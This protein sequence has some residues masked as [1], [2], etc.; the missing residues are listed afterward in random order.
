MRG[1]N[2][3]NSRLRQ[4]LGWEPQISLEEGL[5]RTY[6][7]DRGAGG[8]R[9]DCCARDTSRP[10]VEVNAGVTG[11]IR[12]VRTPACH[13]R[14]RQR[15]RRR[16]ERHHH[17][18]RV[19]AS[20]T[21]DC[22]RRSPVRVRHGRARRHGEPGSTRHSATSTTGPGWSR[23]TACRSSGSAVLHGLPARRAGLRS[24]FDARLLRSVG[25]EGLSPFLLRRR[26]GRGRASAP[27]LQERF[28]GLRVAGTW[29]PAVSRADAGGGTS[30]R[31]TGSTPRSPTSCGSG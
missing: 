30:R 23:R 25:R 19:R 8:A 24:R 16:R 18:G 14:A 17:G 26:A 31:S 4:V 29:S 21:L 15:A 28:P 6:S 11:L 13:A 22:D 2:S 5:A 27:R 7:V 3:D 9:K 12:P 20:S 10:H 1:R